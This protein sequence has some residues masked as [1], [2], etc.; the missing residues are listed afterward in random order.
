MTSSYSTD[1]KLELIVTGEKSG[2]WG[3]ITNTNLNILQQAI[4]GFEAVSIAGGVQTTALL[5]SSG[6]L[7][8]GKNAVIGFTGT[9]S[10]NQTVTIPDGIEKT[11]YVKNSTVGAFTVEFK[12]VSGTG[13]TWTTTD[14]GSKILYSDGTNLYDLNSSLSSIGLVNQNSIQFQ[15]AT[16]GEFVALKA[17]ATISS[18]YTLA[19]PTATGTAGQAIVTD[20]SGNLSFDAAGISTGKAIAMAIVFG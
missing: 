12:T 7:S 1:L 20:G 15:D 19:L 6:V 13:T 5:F 11:Y 17:P 18:G 14:K 16:G 3:D 4:A 8:N 10:G 2:T 9:I